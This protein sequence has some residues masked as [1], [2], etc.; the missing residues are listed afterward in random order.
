M[1]HRDL[2]EENLHLGPTVI[3][4]YYF[5]TLRYNFPY[6][7]HFRLLENCSKKPCKI[8]SPNYPGIYPRN[9]S[10]HYRVREK[11]V[12]EGK[13]ALITVRQANFHYKEHL[14]K[15]DNSDRVLR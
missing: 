10:C 2:I 11:N 8:Q 15:F 1:Q 9:V 13:H 4:N 5:R 14:P 3:G 12:P 7:I 6:L